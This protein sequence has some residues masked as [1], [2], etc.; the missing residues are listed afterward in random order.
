MTSNLGLVLPLKQRLF[1]VLRRRKF[2]LATHAEV[3][4]EVDVGGHPQ[5]R[6]AAKVKSSLTLTA[7]HK[8]P[9]RSYLEAA[10]D[11]CPILPSIVHLE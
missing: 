8:P 3:V 7:L 4:G 9:A 6:T 11:A 5:A 2:R 10:A 1:H